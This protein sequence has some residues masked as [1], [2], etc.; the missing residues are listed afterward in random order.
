MKLLNLIAFIMK[1]CLKYTQIVTIIL[2]T[3]NIKK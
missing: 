1:T 2:L 3:L